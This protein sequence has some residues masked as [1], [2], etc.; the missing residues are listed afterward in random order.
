MK[1][2]VCYQ[3]ITIHRFHDLLSVGP[4]DLCAHCEL[5]FNRKRGPI[6]F[7]DN[8]WLQQVIARLEKGD[9]ILIK[10]FL[11]SFNREIKRQLKIRNQVTV[12][13]FNALGPYPWFFILMEQVKQRLP[14]S[15]TLLLVSVEKADSQT[16]RLY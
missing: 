4:I 2:L 6:L 15:T 13:E 12:L 10:L 14:S 8:D 9:M 5:S 11:S 7:E 16:I 1:C 3:E